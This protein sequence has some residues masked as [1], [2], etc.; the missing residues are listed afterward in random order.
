MQYIMDLSEFQA[1]TGLRFNKPELLQ[2]ALT[3]RSYLNEHDDETLRDNE[4]LE[5]L[6]DSILDYLVTHMLF[7]RFPEMPEGELTRLRAALV[8]T[9]TLAEVAGAIR[10]GEALRMGRGEES[11]G[12]RLRRNIRCDAFEA[13][14]GALYLDQGLEA[15]KHFALPL[16]LPRVD[17]IM[18]E[19]MHWD[20]H[21]LTP[22]YRVIDSSG[23][24]HDKDFT[25]EVVIGERVFGSGSG[26]SKQMAA[27]TAARGV[28]RQIEEG[29][30]PAELMSAAGNL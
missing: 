14:L 7:S 11:S 18:A 9:E 5:F 30:L 21:G 22:V 17:Y 28:L 29:Q 13:L 26:K 12:G 19:G 1:L 25:V 16:L 20:V 27:Q 10:I 8:R 24:D 3:H 6:G 23:P 2:E 15:V 4:R